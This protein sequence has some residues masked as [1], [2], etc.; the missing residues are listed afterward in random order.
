MTPVNLATRGSAHKETQEFREILATRAQVFKVI[1]ELEH[2]ATPAKRATQEL[3]HRAIPGLGR[4]GIQAHLVIPGRELKATQE[5]GP[6][7]IQVHPEIL[8]QV[9][10][11]I[12]GLA[13]KATLGYPVIRGLGIPV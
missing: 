3:G 2:R 6:R 13:R 8:A 1:L 9:L 4:R 5:L 7:E 10:R 12:L 11:V